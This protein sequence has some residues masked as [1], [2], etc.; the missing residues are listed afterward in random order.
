MCALH[1]ISLPTLS[2]KT[3]KK[4]TKNQKLSNDLSD[5][6]DSKGTYS[7]DLLGKRPFLSDLYTK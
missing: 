2:K 7:S 1:L 6:E 5:S 4:D 3:P